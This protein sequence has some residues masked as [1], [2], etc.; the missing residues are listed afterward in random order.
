M[1][2]QK[3]PPVKLSSR[4]I[5]P[6][7]VTWYRA[8]W[9]ITECCGDADLLSRG[10]ELARTIAHLHE[11]AAYIVDLLG[12]CE[13]LDVN[14]A[15]I[16]FNHSPDP[17][18]HL[19]CIAWG[20]LPIAH[21]LHAEIVKGNPFAQWLFAYYCLA[22]G[23]SP[24]AFRAMFLSA[25]QDDPDGLTYMGGFDGIPNAGLCAE[26]AAK[27]GHPKAQV[28]YSNHFNPSSPEWFYW[29]LQS[30]QLSGNRHGAINLFV[31]DIISCTI[32]SFPLE[33]LYQIWDSIK[34]HTAPGPDRGC[35]IFGINYCTIEPKI[36]A[37][38]KVYTVWNQQS[39]AAVYAACRAFRQKR[40]V[41]RDVRNLICRTI[42]NARNKA[43]YECNV[44]EFN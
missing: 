37:C 36:S 31:G 27:L 28:D 41:N 3:F 15:K 1:A 7:L 39:R 19:Y 33:S 5:T 26:R 32:T 24:D 42:W 17:R 29:V 35:F 44:Q 43:G 16:L 34:D 4:E 13:P 2:S 30:A 40:G 6:T 8:R 18:G 20:E 9:C 21:L 23:C 12:Q 38:R 14:T 11:E 25:T 22:N 10:V